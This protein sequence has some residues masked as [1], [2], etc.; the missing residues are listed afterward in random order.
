MRHAGGAGEKEHQILFCP[1]GAGAVTM[2]YF[3]IIFTVLFAALFVGLS[4]DE[5][6]S[7]I[8]RESLLSKNRNSGSTARNI[9]NSSSANSN[10][11]SSNLNQAKQVNSTSFNSNNS[12]GARNLNSSS[13]FSNSNK[14]GAANISTSS[15]S[16]ASS[17]VFSDRGYSGE[18]SNTKFDNNKL[19]YSQLDFN[20][21]IKP[22]VDFNQLI[23]NKIN[24]APLG[25]KFDFNKI[26]LNMINFNKMDV[27]NIQSFKIDPRQIM[28]NALRQLMKQ[29]KPSNNILTAIKKIRK[30]LKMYQQATTLLNAMSKDMSEHSDNEEAKMNK[31]IKKTDKFLGEDDDE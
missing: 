27:S 29:H 1:T 23:G 13:G 20:Q 7:G 14:S 6:N 12:G 15:S 8:A 28:M 3:K 19:V 24:L 22:K 21:L 17:N 16:S 18:G 9:G 11:R 31:I 10:Q 5:E 25:M 30:G 2:N 26:N 4:A